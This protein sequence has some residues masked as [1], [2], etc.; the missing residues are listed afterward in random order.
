[1]TRFGG[2][3]L[4]AAFALVPLSGVTPLMGL[5]KVG[6]VEFGVVVQGLEGLVPEQLLDVVEVG[7]ALDH[8]GRAAAPERVRRD[9]DRQFQLLGVLVDSGTHAVLPQRPAVG[10]DEDGVR[11]GPAEQVRP[12]APDVGGQPFQGGL[13]DRHEAFLPALPDDTGNALLKVKVGKYE[14]FQFADADAGR[15]KQLDGGSVH[16]AVRRAGVDLAHELT[17]LG[18]RQHAVRQKMRFPDVL[19]M[20][21]QVAG[22][23]TEFVEIV[24]EWADGFDHGVDAGR[25]PRQALLGK[26]LGHVR[27]KGVDVFQG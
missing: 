14:S 7:V 1:M 18:M 15:V 5:L 10:V 13:A 23:V 22:D 26:P 9:G 4:L 12:Y 8:L 19:K 25:F 21:G 16:D 11:P 20:P 24:E 27:L 17:D 3:F 2:A 6:D